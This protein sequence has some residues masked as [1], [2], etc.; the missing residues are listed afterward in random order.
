[1]IKTKHTSN[2]KFTNKL[3]VS[4]KRSLFITTFLDR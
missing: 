4:N 1:M 2:S 3:H